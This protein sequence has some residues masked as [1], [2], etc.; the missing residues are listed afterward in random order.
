MN[1][2][3]K[4]NIKDLKSDWSVLSWWETIDDTLTLRIKRKNKKLS[5][6]FQVTERK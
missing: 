1:D 3:W 4:K 5:I 2:V 6:E